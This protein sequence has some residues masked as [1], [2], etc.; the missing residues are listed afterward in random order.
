MR[1]RL[2]VFVLGALLLLAV[3]VILFGQL[4]TLFTRQFHYVVQLPEAPGLD[5][6]APVRKSGIRIGEVT[7]IDL[8]PDTGNV[9]VRV[10]VDRK[11]QLRRN[12]MANL[13]R[14]LVLGEAA[15]NFV[16]RPGGEPAP[17]GF[18]F[19][20]T[21]TRFEENLKKATE[22]VP[23][24]QAAMEEFQRAAKNFNDLV[25]ELRKSNAEAQV[26]LANVGRAAETTDNLLR[27]NQERLAK[28]IENFNTS[29]GRLIDL[30]SDENV[31]HF[32]AMLK[33][34]RTASD[35]LPGFFSDENQRNATAALKGLRDTTDKISATLTDENRQNVTALLKNLK[36]SSDRLDAMMTNFDAT[37]ADARKALQTFTDKT[38]RSRRVASS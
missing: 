24:G 25:P 27:G 29:A 6:G 15:I 7:G 3:L 21:V 26:A 17:D 22:L 20:G 31:R 32:N 37:T 9:T 12:D 19:Q 5:Q 38:E 4:P 11:Y 33:N 30:L 23:T 28:A 34:L 36:A 16:P 18:V 13:G 2:G 14:G 8:D 1:F 35:S 10:N